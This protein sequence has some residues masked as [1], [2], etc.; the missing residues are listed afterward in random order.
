M[1]KSIL[2]SNSVQRL[3]KTEQ[4][5]I[6]G[7]LPNDRYY[8]ECTNSVGAWHGNYSS[9]SAAEDSLEEWCASGTGNCWHLQEA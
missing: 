3:K 7:G 6:F 8:C 1:L 5:S 9:Q 2:N 4:K